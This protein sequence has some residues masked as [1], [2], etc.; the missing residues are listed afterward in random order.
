VTRTPHRGRT[1]TA[2]VLAIAT[3]LTAC[4]SDA[5][6]SAEPLEPD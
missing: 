1:L 6:I 4:G 5:S 2:I 3:L